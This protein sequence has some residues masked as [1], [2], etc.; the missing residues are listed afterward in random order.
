MPSR[1]SRCIAELL[2]PCVGASCSVTI[3]TSRSLYWRKRF[4]CVIHANKGNPFPSFLASTINRMVSALLSHTGQAPRLLIVLAVSVV[5]FSAFVHADAATASALAQQSLGMNRGAIV[6]ENGG[7][8][9]HS[10]PN[11]EPMIDLPG[12]TPIVG[13]RDPHGTWHGLE[14]AYGPFLAGKSRSSL[15]TFLTHLAGRTVPGG[16]LDL[17]I[18]PHIQRVA[19]S[20]LG[21]N[22]GAVI[23][24]DPQTGAIRAMV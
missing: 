16:Q 6:D 5:L 13:Y 8:V 23:A 19:A 7:I 18:D 17:T 20:A 3:S 10:G 4:A 15:G 24:I 21:K 12:L 14:A 11:G 22:R 2:F 9:V 1:T